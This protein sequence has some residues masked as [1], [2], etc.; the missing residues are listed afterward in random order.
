MTGYTFKNRV[1][2]PLLLVFLIL[3]SLSVIVS[4]PPVWHPVYRHTMEE[5]MQEYVASKLL[6][7]DALLISDS[8]WG[9]ESYE[10]VGGK[11]KNHVLNDEEKAHFGDVRWLL[12]KAAGAAIVLLL[13]L[14]IFRKRFRWRTVWGHALLMYLGILV[15]CGIWSAISWRSLFRGLHWVIFMND[16]WILPISSYSLFLFPHK[17][18]QFAGGL[19]L[20]GTLVILLAGFLLSLCFSRKGKTEPEESATAI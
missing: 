4:L 10:D 17:L 9:N 20:G 1:L 3:C 13:A 15:T 14:A 8:L 6:M 5:G 7:E 2:A 18:W 11:L 16:S 12:R 19:V